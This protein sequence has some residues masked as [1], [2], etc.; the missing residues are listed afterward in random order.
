MTESDPEIY[1]VACDGLSAA[2]KGAVIGR[3]L[4]APMLSK[5]AEAS[6]DL[7]L[8]DHVHI[9]GG[10]VLALLEHMGRTYG[11]E[12][13]KTVIRDVVESAQFGGARGQGVH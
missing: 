3:Q 11:A 7:P 13:T 12:I 2:L 8:D 6:D 9:F 10:A 1:A 5:I 4:F